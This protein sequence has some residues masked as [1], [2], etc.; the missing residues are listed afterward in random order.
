MESQIRSD[1]TRYRY[2]DEQHLEEALDRIFR[3]AKARAGADIA[4]QCCD[5]G[6]AA[7]P[8]RAKLSALAFFLQSGG[9][10]RNQSPK[11]MRLREEVVGGRY[12]LVLGFDSP[13]LPFEEW[14]VRPL[15]TCASLRGDDF[16]A[17]L[18]A[19]TRQP[20][21]QSFFGPGVSALVVKDGESNVSV[22][23]VSDGTVA[24]GVAPDEEVLIPLLP[25][26]PPRVV[27]KKAQ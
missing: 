20:K 26:L 17:L 18:P 23:L 12:A 10:R 7:P 11:L 25:G 27:K 19:Q 5:C 2:G 21:I 16:P 8:L 9:I 6:S 14:E 4:E 24:G 15:I 22:S 3:V 1:V 13:N